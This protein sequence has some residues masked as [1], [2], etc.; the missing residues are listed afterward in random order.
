MTSIINQQD[1][2]HAF[3]LLDFVASD[4]QYQ[5]FIFVSTKKVVELIIKYHFRFSFIESI[6]NRLRSIFVESTK[7]SRIWLAKWAM[8]KTLVKRVIKRFNIVTNHLIDVNEIDKITS[9]N[10]QSNQC[11]STSNKEINNKI[12]QFAHSSSNVFASSC[13]S[14]SKKIDNYDQSKRLFSSSILFS[15]IIFVKVDKKIDNQLKAFVISLSRSY[16]SSHESILEKNDNSSSQT[17]RFVNLFSDVFVSSNKSLSTF[18]SFVNSYST[19]QFDI[20]Y[21][22]SQFIMTSRFNRSFDDSKRSNFNNFLSNNVEN[23]SETQ[24]STTELF[25]ASRDNLE[26][27]SRERNRSF[28]FFSRQF[29]EETRRQFSSRRYKSTFDQINLSLFFYQMQENLLDLFI[30]QIKQLDSLVFDQ[31]ISSRNENTSHITQSR[32]ARQK[33][34]SQMIKQLRDIMREKIQQI[35]ST[36]RE[37]NFITNSNSYSSNELE[38]VVN[39]FKA[40]DFD[41]FHLDVFE[42]YESNDIIFVHKKTIYREVFIFVQRINDYV[43][44]INEFVVRENLFFCFRDAIMTWYFKEIYDFKCKTFR[45]VSF[46]EFIDEL[47]ARFKMR[48]NKILDKFIAKI[49]IVKNVK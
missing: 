27:K 9:F 28:F 25:H 8:N 22:A 38:I 11:H 49:F 30:K 35:A 40:I 10:L 42:N 21:F 4:H 39:R 2:V 46:V 44:V 45:S 23:L 1:I 3:Q 14:I 20:S 16:D 12:E 36:S 48:I 15:Q 13:T 43:Y 7:K 29:D 47:K 19:S 37:Y 34:I 33:F 18:S 17:Y 41:F 32:E 5:K 26:P 31:S 24:D 6:A